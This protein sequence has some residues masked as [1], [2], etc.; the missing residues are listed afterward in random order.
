MNNKDFDYIIKY[1]QEYH[2]YS[3]YELIQQI[4]DEVKTLGLKNLLC[5]MEI[6]IKEKK[7]YALEP[8]LE[9]LDDIFIK[10]NK[11]ELIK[12]LE[13]HHTQITDEFLKK[14]N[15]QKTRTKNK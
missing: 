14:I 8:I 9:S 4:K 5:L 2:E 3:D 13:E 7:Y 12:F 10:K 11:Q 15:T 1:L 6:I